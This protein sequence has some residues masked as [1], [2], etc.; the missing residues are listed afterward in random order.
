MKQ[1]TERYTRKITIRLKPHEFTQVEAKQKA[2][3]CNK[4][5]EYARKM[6]LGEPVTVTYR[7]KGADELLKEML[8]LKNELNAIGNNFNQVVHKLHTLDTIP[9]IKAW[10]KLN[11]AAKQTMLEKIEQVRIRMNQLYNL[12]S[13]Q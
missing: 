3:T 2:T 11:E 9:E 13:H 4:L 6:L 12:W 7:N 10:A 5:S 8:Q 1:E